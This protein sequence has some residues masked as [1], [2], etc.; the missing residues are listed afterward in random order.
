M[1]WYS[2]YFWL[3]N[4]DEPF[5]DVKQADAILQVFTVAARK[6]ECKLF[7]VDNLMTT[8]ADSDE[9]WRAQAVFVNSM[10]QFAKHYNAH[11]L[12]VAHA[13]KVKNGE[14]I[15]KADVSGSSAIVNL[16]DS[17]I[18]SERPNLRIIKNRDDGEQRLI[19]CVYCGDSRRIYEAAHG[20]L[21]KFSWDKS[22]LTPPKQRADSM[23]EYGPKFSDDPAT[24]QPF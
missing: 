4:N 7:L 12:I 10:K 24:R 23:P 9:E 13:R 5:V 2:P 17:A 19:E 18:V 11:V 14:K 15:N 21:N 1:D 3:Y 20:D 22:G 6:E 16:A 8:T